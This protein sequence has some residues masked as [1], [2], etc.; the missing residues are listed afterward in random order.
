MLLEKKNQETELDIQYK[1]KLHEYHEAK[2]KLKADE[3]RKELDN[4]EFKLHLREQKK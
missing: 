1:N 4:I 3:I 2:S